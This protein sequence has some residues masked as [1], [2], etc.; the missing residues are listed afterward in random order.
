[1]LTRDRNTPERAGDHLSLP[2]AANAVIHAG[3]LVVTNATGYAAPGSTALNLR[4]AGRAEEPVDNTGGADGAE[5][6]RVSRGVFKFRNSATDP[7]GQAHL[8]GDAYI[9]DD[10]TVAAT[11]GTNTR[12][13]AGKI[14]ALDSDGVWVEIR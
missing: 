8:L 3:A 12:S 9:E 6:V 14:L 1:M 10:E 4:A 7:I 13:R 5:T 11:N 2:V